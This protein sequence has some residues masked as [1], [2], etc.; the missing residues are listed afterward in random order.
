MSL[1]ASPLRLSST[2]LAGEPRPSDDTVFVVDQMTA[3]ARLSALA[4]AHASDPRHIQAAAAELAPTVPVN[5]TPRSPGVVT[6]LQPGTL[7]PAPPPTLPPT[8]A[9]Q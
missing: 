8:P 9:A 6:P 3:G 2:R 4:S 1:S 7:L 5:I